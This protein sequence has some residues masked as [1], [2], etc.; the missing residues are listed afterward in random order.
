VIAEALREA[1][2]DNPRLRLIVVVRPVNEGNKSLVHP[3]TY[4]MASCPDRSH[5]PQT[6]QRA[7]GRPRGPPG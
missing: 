1:L 7:T 5:P 6:E 3:S 4:W 2:H